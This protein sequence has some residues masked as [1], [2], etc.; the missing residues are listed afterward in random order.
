[1]PIARHTHDRTVSTSS[2]F[3][4]ELPSSRFKVKEVL[5]YLPRDRKVHDRKEQTKARTL[6]TNDV[7]RQSHSV[8]ST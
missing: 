6:D 2:L 1:M 3:P 4:V 5:V 8:S 7:S